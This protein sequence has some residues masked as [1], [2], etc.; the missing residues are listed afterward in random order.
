MDG[1]T[2]GELN[3][4]ALDAIADEEPMAPSPTDSALL[5][6]ITPVHATVIRLDGQP[7]FELGYRVPWDDEHTIGAR[8]RDGALVDLCGS[9]ASF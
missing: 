2:L 4:L 3:A 9:V 1:G 7:T 6:R 5:A 8:F